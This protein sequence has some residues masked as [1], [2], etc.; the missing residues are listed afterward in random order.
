L[1]ARLRRSLVAEERRML[2]VE[3]APLR[4]ACYETPW[5]KQSLPV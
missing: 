1:D 3:E 2:A 5:A 4:V